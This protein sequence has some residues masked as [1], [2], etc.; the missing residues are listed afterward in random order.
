MYLELLPAA[1]KK[2]FELLGNSGLVSNFY[3][4]G[5]TGLA[6]YLGHRYSY[7]LVFFSLKDFDESAIIQRFSL[8]NINRDGCKTIS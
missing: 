6:L 3:L 4:A 8:F 7:G 5:G 2:T 1:I